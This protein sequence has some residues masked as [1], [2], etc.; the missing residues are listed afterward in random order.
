MSLSHSLKARRIL[1]RHFIIAIL[2]TA[3]E[4]A[5]SQY[6]RQYKVYL[7]FLDGSVA[8]WW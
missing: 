3:R 1:L 5:Y 4:R 6:M 2:T 7:L 8:V